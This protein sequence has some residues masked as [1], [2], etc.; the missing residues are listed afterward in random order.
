MRRMG[1]SDG[2][3]KQAGMFEEQQSAE[4][5]ST[6]PRRANAPS[7]VAQVEIGRAGVGDG[8]VVEEFALFSLL[9]PDE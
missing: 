2:S 1:L 7:G 5:P 6:G 3:I 8:R 4:L 9:L